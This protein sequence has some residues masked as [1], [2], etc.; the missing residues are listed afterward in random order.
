MNIKNKKNIYTIKLK[1]KIFK[2]K[3]IQKIIIYLLRNLILI[4]SYLIYKN[5]I[6]L[7]SNF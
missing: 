6:K 7:A 2:K 1:N 4:Q 5:M 3:T